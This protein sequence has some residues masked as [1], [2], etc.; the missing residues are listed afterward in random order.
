MATLNLF[1]ARVAFVNTDGTLTPESYR[2]LQ[3]LFNRVGGASAPTI[4]ELDAQ[5]YADAGIEETKSQLFAMA[6]EVGSMPPF[7]QQ[8]RDEPLPPVYELVSVDALMAEIYE[9]RETVAS[10][11]N[12]IHDLQKGLL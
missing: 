9:L 11:Q 5:Q 10:L 7:M 4:T 8:M 12:Q 6:A 1:P 3:V 2:A